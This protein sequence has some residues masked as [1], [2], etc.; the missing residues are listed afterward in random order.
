M[1][2]NSIIFT[3][4]FFEMLISYIF[5][6]QI[7][8]RKLNVFYCLFIGALFFESGALLNITLGNIVWFNTIYFAIINI[9]F[10][11]SCFR[12]KLARIIY[13]SVLLDIFS[14]AF[15][16]AT[17]FLISVITQTEAT[18]Y[19]SKMSMLIIEVIIS[20]VL[21]LFTCLVLAR[22]LTKEKETVKFP[23][24]LYVYPIIIVIVL[25]LFWSVCTKSNITKSQQIML[26]TASIALLFSI[27]I[28]FIIFQHSIEK[29]NRLFLLQN[30][31][32]RLEI[33]KSYYDILEKQNE[34]LM[35]YVHDTKKHL[36]AIRDLNDNEQI[37]KY[38]GTMVDQLKS[39]S[40]NC[41]SGNHTLD[42]LINKCKTE[43]NIKNIVF[44]FDVHLANFKYVD[45]Y[46]LVTILGNILENALEAANK[47]ENKYIDLSSDHRN[48]YDILI[49]KNSCDSSPVCNNNELQTTK[50]NKMLH[51]L[52]MKSALKTLRKYDGDLYWEYDEL[53]KEFLTTIMIFKGNI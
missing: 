11:F 15:E 39:Y 36:A 4:Y 26:A 1:L 19:L 43:C 28:L 10:S 34:D 12:I 8:D 23:L 33:D 50:S 30:E 51:G 40:S 47:S 48:T 2:Y 6:S 9:A 35:I 44:T 25:L 37:D 13:Y 31:L 45:S 21:Y 49:I 29:E 17:I 24:G 7:G 52:G 16:F 53:K 22:F 27:I 5:F 41:H 32:E 18:A 3:V 38:I 42:V 20:K 46:D 14:T